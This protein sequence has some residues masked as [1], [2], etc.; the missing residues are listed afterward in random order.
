MT[1]VRTVPSHIML[2]A[3]GTCQCSTMD[4][5]LTEVRSTYV[6]MIQAVSPCSDWTQDWPAGTTRSPVSYT[7]IRYFK[8]SL[9]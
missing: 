2:Q 8:I 4:N 5:T 9:L 7:L 1:V 3:T 6:C